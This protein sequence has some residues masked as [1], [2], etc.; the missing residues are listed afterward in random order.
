[1]QMISAVDSLAWAEQE[2]GHIQTGH[3]ARDKREVNMLQRMFERPNGHITQI[4]PKARER[5]AAFR[6]LESRRFSPD[7][8]NLATTIAAVRRAANFDEIYVAIDGTSLALDSTSA[9]GLSEIGSKK[10]TITGLHIQNSIIMAQDGQVLGVGHQRYYSRKRYP[11][12]LTRE[13][14][15]ALPFEKKESRYW[16][17]CIQENEKAFVSEGIKG[18][19]TYLMDRGADILQILEYANTSDCRIIVRSNHER[20]LFVTNEDGTE[21][22]RHLKKEIRSALIQGY[23]MLYVPAGA[24]RQ[25]RT[26]VMEIQ[27]DPYTFRLDPRQKGKKISR[28]ELTVVRAHE[29][30][31]VPT[32]EKPIEWR[33]LCNQPV[34]DFEQAAEVVYAYTRRW[35]IEEMHRCLK[36][37]CGVEHTQLRTTSALTK[38]AMLMS[39]VAVRIEQLKTVSR[40]EPDAPATQLFSPEELQ[41][42]MLL[43]FQREP[44]PTEPP[45][46]EKAVCWLAQLGGYIGPRNGPP[47][48]QTIGRG[49]LRL[50]E[51]MELLSI[52]K[53]IDS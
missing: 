3:K 1:M 14:R 30:S 33:L 39:S 23:Y 16:L 15:R 38:F 29:V 31:P 4:F 43:H 53:D 7:A 2:L 12:R 28:A 17:E 13:E 51:S 52:I 27:S 11:K 22:R 47:G 8:I 32:G 50:Q 10:S 40:A 45:T 25:E 34:E 49:L 19:R 46:C 44:F 20:G 6:A 5:Q 37:V 36:T 9:P 26:A 42:I 48:Q 21:E 35:R 41:V 18:R 24:G